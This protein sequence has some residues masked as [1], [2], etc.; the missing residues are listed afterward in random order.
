M[1]IN[2]SY[3]FDNNTEFGVTFIKDLPNEVRNLSWQ[4]WYVN[5]KFVSVVPHLWHLEDHSSQKGWKRE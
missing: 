2:T 5:Y 3:T 4:P 1:I